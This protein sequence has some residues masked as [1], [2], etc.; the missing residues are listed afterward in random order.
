MMASAIASGMPPASATILSLQT[1]P[2]RQH[3][4]PS[5]M[6]LTVGQFSQHT[7]PTPFHA[8]FLHGWGA[9]ESK[10]TQRH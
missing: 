3:S 10:Q 1:V 4:A 5:D 8:E 2:L 6:G 7:G 9:H